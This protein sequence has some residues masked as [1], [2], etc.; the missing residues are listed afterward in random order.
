MWSDIGK[1]NALDDMIKDTGEESDVDLNEITYYDYEDNFWRYM[2]FIDSGP[3]EGG[4]T[5]YK[6]QQSEDGTGALLLV[7]RTYRISPWIIARWV[8]VSGEIFGRGPVLNALPDAKTINLAKRLELQNASLAVAGVWLVK[9]NGV[10]NPNTITIKPGSIIPVMSTGGS[11]GAD[12][13]P[14]Q[15]GNQ[16]TY[17]QIVIKDLTESIKEAMFDRSIPVQGAVRSATEWMVRQRMLQEAIGAPFGRMHQEFIRPLFRRMLDILQRKAYIDES[18]SLDG[19]NIDVQIVGSLAQTQALKEVETISN[20]GAMSRDL[21]GQE[22]FMMAA[23]TESIPKKL[24]ELL[25]VDVE[26]LRTEEEKKQ[27]L[28]VLMSQVQGSSSEETQ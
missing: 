2:V 16:L 6:G 27:F 20:W 21:A 3:S 23:K 4:G 12:L 18:I 13:Q 9:N 24:A 22:G 14:L 8:K 5:G 19:S 15:M 28:E 17:S 11:Q 10:I 1:N 25:G 26:L 7:E